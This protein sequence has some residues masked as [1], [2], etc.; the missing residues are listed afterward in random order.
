[1]TPPTEHNRRTDDTRLALLEQAVR[2]TEKRH[3]ENK[4][5]LVAV[6]KRISEGNVSTAAGLKVISDKLDAT[7]TN[8]SLHTVQTS[9][10]ARSF[11]YI[12]TAIYILG[13]GALI[14]FGWIYGHVTG[15]DHTALTQ[16]LGNLKKL[17]GAL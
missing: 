16:L 14:I 6:H 12:E 17:K 11:G 8:C 7:L 10:L 5:S 2:A 13:V 9:V 15:V 1:M 3:E 4:E